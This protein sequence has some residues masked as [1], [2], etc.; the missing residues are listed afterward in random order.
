MS[1]VAERASPVRLTFGAGNV[2]IEAQ[3]DGRARAMETVPADFEGDERVISFSPHY[4][5]DGLAA[6]AAV[7]RHGPA[8][9]RRRAMTRT[10]RRPIPGRS[11]S[12][13][14]ARPSPR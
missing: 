5:L 14:P 13:S 4:L 3:T 12:S 9:G 11:G 2:V 7:G 6:A 1:L 8:A 10:R